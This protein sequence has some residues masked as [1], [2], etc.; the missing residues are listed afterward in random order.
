MLLIHLGTRVTIQAA[1]GFLFTYM[2]LCQY[3]VFNIARKDCMHKS[4]NFPLE[5]KTSRADSCQLVLK[6]NQVS[7]RK[8]AG[9]GLEICLQPTNTFFQFWGVE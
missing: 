1:L 4:G 5:C 2:Y 9:E 7:L 6:S 3:V 8:N